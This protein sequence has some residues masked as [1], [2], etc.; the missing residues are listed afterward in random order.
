MIVK[1]IRT[2]SDTELSVQLSDERNTVAIVLEQE[3]GTDT[4][5]VQ[6]TFLDSNQVDELIQTL[7]ELKSKMQ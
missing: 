6:V 1:K 4:D 2:N 3:I 5:G 7:E